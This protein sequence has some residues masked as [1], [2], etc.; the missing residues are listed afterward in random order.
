M[1]MT[2]GDDL[3]VANGQ[4]YQ[5]TTPSASF[6]TLTIQGTGTIQLSQDAKVTCNTLIYQA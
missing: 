6:N 4:V 3:T 5:L 2:V 1:P